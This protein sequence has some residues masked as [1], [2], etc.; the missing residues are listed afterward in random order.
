MPTTDLVQQVDQWMKSGGLESWKMAY[1]QRDFG[2]E[3]L[4]EV[5]PVGAAHN[6]NLG[7]HLYFSRFK[8]QKADIVAASEK[9]Q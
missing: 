6:Y 1:L 4:P 3:I 2:L 9:G 7:R 8:S 5:G